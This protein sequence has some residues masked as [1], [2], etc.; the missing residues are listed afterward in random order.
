MVLVDILDSRTLQSEDGQ[1]HGEQ[2]GVDQR[3]HR[4]EDADMGHERLVP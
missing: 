2:E 3:T 4:L 1:T